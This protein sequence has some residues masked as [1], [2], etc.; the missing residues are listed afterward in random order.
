MFPK[1][2]LEDYWIR[3]D[4]GKLAFP[5]IPSDTIL[6]DS[7]PITL[8][9]VFLK[10]AKFGGD[11]SLHIHNFFTLIWKDLMDKAIKGLDGRIGEITSCFDSTKSTISSLETS[12][13]DS[14]T[15]VASGG[16]GEFGFYSMYSELER[17]SWLL[18]NLQASKCR[19]SN[20]KDQIRD[21]RSVLGLNKNWVGESP[22]CIWRE[23][24]R[25]MYNLSI[26]E[27]CPEKFM[28]HYPGSPD[29]MDDIRLFRT[30]V[31]GSSNWDATVVRRFRRGRG[32]LIGYEGTQN[33]DSSTFMTV[34]NPI[35]WTTIKNKLGIKRGKVIIALLTM[36]RILNL[37]NKPSSLYSQHLWRYLISL[38]PTLS[39]TPPRPVIY[40]SRV[41]IPEG[42]LKD[43]DGN[44]LEDPVLYIP[45]EVGS[46]VHRMLCC[47]NHFCEDTISGIIRSGRSPKCPMC[48]SPLFLRDTTD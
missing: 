48:R 6:D 8:T 12:L 10:S 41:T 44:V 7:M 24:E 9:D 20:L 26:A 27:Q 46:T 28:S 2:S 38:S 19:I 47:G 39:P 31:E 17:Y 4:G 11:R 5:D 33:S 42:G 22:K 14:I 32:H 35:R 1:M 25:D 29:S 34:F 30:A 40:S 45:F 36:D 16:R 43:S 15:S 37:G 3:S 13:K 21:T 23:E 18:R